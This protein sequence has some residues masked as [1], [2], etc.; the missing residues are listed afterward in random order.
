MGDEMRHLLLATVATL[1]AVQATGAH[2]TTYYVSPIGK[3]T[4]AGTTPNAPFLTIQHA[5]DRTNPGDVVNI[6]AG[7]YGTFVIKRSGTQAA[8]IIYQNYAGQRAVIRRV[9]PAGNGIEIGPSNN[10]VSWVVV[11]GLVVRG[12]AD[13]Y[14][15]ATYLNATTNDPLINGSCIDAYPSGT[16]LTFENNDVSFCPGAGIQALGDNIVIHG[17]RVHNNSYWAPSDFSGIIVQGQ[18][19]GTVVVDGNLVWANQNYQ[20]NRLEVPCCVTDGRGI[21]VDSQPAGYAGRV[22][23]YNNVVWNN[24]LVGIAVVRSV[25]VDIY[26]NTLYQ[27]N[28]SCI[29]PAPYTAPC[30]EG[31][32]AFGEAPG[33]NVNSRVENNIIYGANYAT[34]FYAPG[35]TLPG[36]TWDYNIE[37]NGQGAYAFGPHDH[38]SDPS[39]TTWQQPPATF[40]LQEGSIAIGT[41]EGTLVPARDADNVLRSTQ[42]GPTRGA[43]AVPVNNPQ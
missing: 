43:Y 31:E 8:P 33:T 18:V 38:V 20:K 17:N 15:A 41:G 2:A 11:R 28:E 22:R 5:A 42:I 34:M 1:V 13:A 10:P 27:N 24:G 21:I 9:T 4:N 37:F 29:E 36:L 26:N 19:N 25:N 39:F 7:T 35:M 12:D 6:T 23:V 3:D 16:S 40:H 32:I 14:P 30:M